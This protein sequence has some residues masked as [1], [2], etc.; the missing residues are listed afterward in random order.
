MTAKVAVGSAE[1]QESLDLFNTRVLSKSLKFE[2]P[3]I[4][5]FDLKKQSVYAPVITS[6]NVRKMVV[7]NECAK[8]LS[9][10]T[11]HPLY[12]IS[13]LMKR[14]TLPSVED[15]KRLALYPPM[16]TKSAARLLITKGCPVILRGNIN[17]GKF[18]IAKG[19]ILH[20]VEPIFPE[21]GTFLEST[22]DEGTAKECT[23]LTPLPPPGRNEHIVGLICRVYGRHDEVFFPE[24]G[25]GLIPVVPTPSVIN[26]GCL[27]GNNVVSNVSCIQLPLFP[28]F[29]L[30]V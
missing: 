12:S 26:V 7:D 17:L 30:V 8:Q 28:A 23:I 2:V 14:N 13:P 5:Q 19:S 11:G 22:L 10:I 9:I 16:L 21:G 3:N 25:P 6:I 18:G 27:T 4:D 1:N 29:S 24:L 20:V 15:F